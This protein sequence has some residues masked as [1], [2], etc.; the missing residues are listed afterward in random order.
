MYEVFLEGIH[1]KKYLSVDFVAKK[2]GLLRSRKCVPLDY[3][4]SQI[5][6][7][8]LDRYHFLDLDSPKGKHPLAILP[9]QIQN[10]TIINESFS[11]TDYIKWTPR[12]MIKRD[13]GLHS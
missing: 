1:D 2:D 10:I 9:E 12:W 13:W 11:P 3:C 4:E 8:G 5:C 6:K 7:D